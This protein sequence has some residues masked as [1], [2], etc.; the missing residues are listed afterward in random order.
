MWIPRE[1]GDFV[2]TRK[3]IHMTCRFFDESGKEVYKCTDARKEGWAWRENLRMKG[4]HMCY[5]KYEVPDDLP[6]DE[7]LKVV[8]DFTGDVAGYR[9]DYPDAKFVILK[10]ASMN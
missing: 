7:K 3:D 8:V 5:G 9:N 10:W 1:V 6:Y 2:P 4:S